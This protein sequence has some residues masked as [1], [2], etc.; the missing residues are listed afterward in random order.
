MCVYSAFFTEAFYKRGNFFDSF[1][2]AHTYGYTAMPT[3]G[4]EV[5]L[6]IRLSTTADSRYPHIDA[7]EE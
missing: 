3:V 6:V 1:P 4:D 7:S 2:S 5:F